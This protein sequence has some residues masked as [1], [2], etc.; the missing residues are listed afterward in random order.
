MYIYIC[1]EHEDKCKYT[2]T[3]EG[4]GCL[5]LIVDVHC[6]FVICRELILM[7]AFSARNKRYQAGCGLRAF[8]RV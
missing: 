1:R 6:K 5:E 8:S 2:H 3:Y 4:K 7:A